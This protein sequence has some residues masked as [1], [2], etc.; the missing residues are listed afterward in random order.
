MHR[1]NS[2]SVRLTVQTTAGPGSEDPD[3]RLLKEALHRILQVSDLAE[4]GL[5]GFAARGELR[6]NSAGLPAAQEPGP[7]ADLRA[8]L[9]LEMATLRAHIGFD[10]FGPTIAGVGLETEWPLCSGIRKGDD[11]AIPL[12]VRS[13]CV[14]QGQARD[15]WFH[16]VPPTCNGERISLTFRTMSPNGASGPG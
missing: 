7:P 4:I 10:T 13:A 14:M 9:R 12:P 16:Q 8:R 15:N 1:P 11:I 2:G 3:A 5:C 6:K